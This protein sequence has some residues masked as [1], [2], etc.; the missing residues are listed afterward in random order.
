MPKLAGQRILLG[1][2]GGI[3]AY[4]SADLVRRLKERGADV[5]VVMTQAAT[6]FVGPLTF[7]AVSGNPVHTD[8]LDPAAEAGMGHIELARW[9][10]HV[11]IAPASANFM[12]QLAAG[13]APDLLTT[14]CLATHAPISLAPAMNH[15][16]WQSAAVQT[17][18]EILEQRGVVLLG[19]GDGAQAC[20]EVGAGRMWEP[21]EIIAALENQAVINGSLSAK[22][23]VITAGPTREALDPVRYLSNHSSGKMG[24]AL[25]RAAQRAGASVTLIAGPV[26]LATPLNVTRIDVVSATDMLQAVDK[27]L[28]TLDMQQ[29]IFIAA[30]AVADYRAEN[31]A[32]QKTKKTSTSLT[33]NLIPNLD[34]LANVAQ[35]KPAPFTVGFAAETQ[36]LAEYAKQKLINK[37]IDMI[38]ANTVGDNQGFNVDT[39]SLQIFWDGGEQHLPETSKT[40][41]A[42]QLLQLMI[43]RLP[44]AKH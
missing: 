37:N 24:F 6:Q 11:L 42:E 26:Q 30:A 19:P 5:R 28:S 14:L 38:A 39:N 40:L 33:I 15:V 4:K 2:T 18:R 34:I 22:H 32:Q 43:T 16:M 31:I 10:N 41:L 35:R 20:G 27:T 36:S 29:T 21:L 1:V 12:G 17:N 7:Q 23:I 8:L 13:F 25:A 9:A 3:A 44:H